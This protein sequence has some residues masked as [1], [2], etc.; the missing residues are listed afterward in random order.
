MEIRQCKVCAKSFKVYPSQIIK[1]VGKF[2]SRACYDKAHPTPPETRFW[3]HIDKS[4]G[5]E[6]CWIWTAGCLKGYG[7]FHFNNHSVRAHRFVYELTYGPI[8]NNLLVCHHCDNRRCCNPK[9]LFLGTQLDNIHDAIAK[10]RTP[11][12][13]KSGRRKHPE[14]YPR[15]E[16]LPFAKLTNDAII[17]IRSLYSSGVMLSKLARQYNVGTTCITNIVQNRTWKHIP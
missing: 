11:L 6:A 16:A 10:G 14:R 13:E 8:L 12:G 15:G 4:G 17:T 7:Y 5:P 1:A 3:S 9:H 2:C